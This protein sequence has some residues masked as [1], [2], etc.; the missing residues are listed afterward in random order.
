MY[1]LKKEVLGSLEQLSE[2]RAIDIYYG[3]EAGVNLEPNVPY[4]WQF[5]DEEFRCRRHAA[6][7]SIVSGYLPETIKLGCHIRDSSDS[8]FC[9]RAV[10]EVFI[11]NLETNRRGLG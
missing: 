10:G 8:G 5:Q 9:S 6:K 11:F 2:A 1:R 4:G 7:A 3:D